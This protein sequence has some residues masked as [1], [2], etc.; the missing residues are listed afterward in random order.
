M[1]AFSRKTGFGGPGALALDLKLRQDRARKNRTWKVGPMERI[2]STTRAREGV[3]TSG[4]ERQDTREEVSRSI[5][6]R[7]D[8]P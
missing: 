5:M 8:D 2:Q 3:S 6:F 7:S 1:V 4:R